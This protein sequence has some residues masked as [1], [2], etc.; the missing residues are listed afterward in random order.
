[1]DD[2]L[3]VTCRQSDIPLIEKVSPSVLDTFREQSG[4]N[5]SLQIDQKHNL[6]EN[7]AGGVIVASANGK[8][9]CDNTLETRLSQAFEGMLPTIR[10]TLFGP[11]P[12]R[13]FF[14]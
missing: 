9:K 1:M 12:N 3:I 5:V 2:K 11:S 8:I 13:K 14:D 10:V 6:S 4:K 7:G